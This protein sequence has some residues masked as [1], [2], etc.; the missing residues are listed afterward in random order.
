MILHTDKDCSSS[1]TVALDMGCN[2][3]VINSGHYADLTFKSNN[4]GQNSFGYY[5]E[6]F[7]ASNCYPYPFKEE[8][9]GNAQENKCYSYDADEINIGSF[10]TILTSSFLNNDSRIEEKKNEEMF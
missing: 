8:M 3:V 4:L 7:N 5:L 9:F 10:P 6:L 1:Q 2:E